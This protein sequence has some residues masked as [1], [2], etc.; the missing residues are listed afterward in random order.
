MA[1]FASNAKANTGLALSG[2]SLGFSLLGGG[3]SWLLGGN[4]MMNGSCCNED[5]LINRYELQKEQRITS[6][7]TENALLKSNIYTDQKSIELYKYVDSKFNT[8]EQAISQQ[9]VYNATINATIGCIQGQVAQLQSLT[10]IVIPGNNI[11]PE[12]MPRYNSWTAPTT[13]A[14]TA[15]PAA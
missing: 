6:L 9:A 14:P 13:P 11:C 15:A 4:R 7:E 2:T 1:E 12:A 10:K 3:L 5:H 8:L